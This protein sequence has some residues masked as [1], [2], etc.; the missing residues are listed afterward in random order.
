M[1]EAEVS[2]FHEA[3]RENVLEEAAEK[4]HGVERGGAWS[5]TAR[6][7]V[8][9]RD[10]AVFE[11]HEAPVGDGDPEDIGGKVLESR[12]AISS[13]L[14]VDVPGEVPDVWVDVLEQSGLAHVFL[15]KGAVDRRE[16]FDGDEEVVSGSEPLGAVLGKST[17]RDD[18]VDVGV[19]LELPAPGMQDTGETRKVSADEAFV[20]GEAFEG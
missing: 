6:L 14:R 17:A 8:G 20:F 18:V 13:R 7:A 16:G 3:F 10:G 12:V 9:E 19:V 15:E 5:S 1:P 11:S 4:L 2:D